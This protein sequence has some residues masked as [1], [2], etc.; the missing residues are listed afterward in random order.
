MKKVLGYI[1]SITVFLCAAQKDVMASAYQEIIEK[2]LG[3]TKAAAADRYQR[4]GVA[5]KLRAY[6]EQKLPKTVIELKHTPSLGLEWAA[7][8]FLLECVQDPETEAVGQL[9]YGM[10]LLIL[11][12]QG[13]EE[14]SV[15]L[16]QLRD[17]LNELK[18]VGAFRASTAIVDVLAYLR[19]GG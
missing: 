7:V 11:H 10:C 4:S 2:H 5:R 17:F 1:V 13:N 9:T 15:L 16:L 12:E 18:E 3:E 19:T 14:Q 6:R 8:A